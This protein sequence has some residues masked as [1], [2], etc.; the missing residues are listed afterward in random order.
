MNTKGKSLRLFLVDGTPQ[1]L[2]TAE[3]MNWTGHILM[4]PRAKLDDLIKRPEMSKTGIYFL[5]GPDPEG[6]GTTF[7]YIGESD[8]VGK[9]LVQHNKDESKEFW[10]RSCIITSKDQN[11]TKAHGR[12]LESRLI[13]IV[14]KAAQVKLLNGTSPVYDVLPEADIAD[15]EYFISQIALVLPVLG[16]DFLRESPQLPSGAE[17]K[18]SKKIPRLTGYDLIDDYQPFEIQ[19]RKY[20]LKA[21]A[22]EFEGEF[23]VLK[24]SETQPRWVGTEDHN[25]RKL[26]ESLF[27]EEKITLDP[28][29]QKGIFRED[30]RFKS[31]SAAAAVI[32]G[33]A[34]NGRKEWKH[35][36][37]SKTYED[38]QNEKLA[39]LKIEEEAA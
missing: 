38:W 34:S 2:L 15:M 31:P 10:E 12:Y 26:F 28:S 21:E 13:S 7:V 9:R 20:Q 14:Q 35:M 30:I 3:I 36:L 17:E 27:K 24:G 11:L 25:Y 37:S 1:G 16:L 23:I 18:G 22:R 29:G 33:R 4:A 39:A 5:T 6:T 8:N 19:S 32:F